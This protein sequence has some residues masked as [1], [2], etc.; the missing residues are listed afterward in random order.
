MKHPQADLVLPLYSEPYRIGLGTYR[1]GENTFSVCLR[2]LELGYRHIDTATLYRNER[3]VG[4]AVK[5]SGIN[6][7]ELFITTKVSVR[8]AENHNISDSVQ[9]SIERLG[10]ID[11]ILLHGPTSYIQRDWD[12]LCKQADT[13]GIP[14]TGVSNYRQEHLE[15]LGSRI[16]A[17][18]Q[19]EVSPFLQRNQ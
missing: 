5:Q 17:V 3:A 10:H 8:D 19:I 13:H 7:N 15:N 2:A 11:L 14:H 9:K 18:N 16:P 6:R 4:E 12:V 1:L